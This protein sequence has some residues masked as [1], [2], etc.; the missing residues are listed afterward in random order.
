MP[1]ESEIVV[2]SGLP[3]SG[4]SLMM[5]ML[6]RGG[7]P[8]LTDAIRA[9]DTDNP[10]GYYE[11]EA[12]KRTKEDASWVPAARG[13]AVKMV[14]SLLYDLPPGERY[15]VIFQRRDFDEM[16]DSQDKMLQRLNKPSAPRD[17]IIQSFKVHL[18]RLFDWLP[19]Q[20]HCC[21][22]PNSSMAPCLLRRCCKRSTRHCIAIVGSSVP[23]V[24][25]GDHALHP[26]S[27]RCSFKPGV[28]C[29]NSLERTNLTC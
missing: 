14:S 22:S 3:R 5:Q 4:T 10:R 12:V 8:A 29:L 25:T 19:K 16:I 20:S 2:V 21:E 1:L 6:D 9:A 24:T 11:Y 26:F 13:K 17:A 28:T 18:D 7:I 27:P 15:R 23:C